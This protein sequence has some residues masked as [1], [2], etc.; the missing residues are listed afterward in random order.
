MFLTFNDKYINLIYNKISLHKTKKPLIKA[1]LMLYLYRILDQVNT[2][3]NKL[4]KLSAG[5]QSL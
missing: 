1:A 5:K 4:C 2:A 3:V